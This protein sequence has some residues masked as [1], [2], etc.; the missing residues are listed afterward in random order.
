[1]SSQA[2]AIA[3]AHGVYNG[4]G[5]RD[6][7]QRVNETAILTLRE[8]EILRMIAA[9][10]RSK[11]IAEKMFVSFPT[12]KNHTCHIFEKLTVNNRNRNVRRIEDD[13]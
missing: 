1:M 5:A 13:A 9:G 12:L 8:L 7:R 2:F 6:N 4:D 11:E 3:N 10:Y